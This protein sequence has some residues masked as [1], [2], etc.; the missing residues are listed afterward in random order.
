VGL[1]DEIAWTIFGPEAIRETGDEKSVLARTDS[2]AK[3]LDRIMA[4]SWVI[5]NRAPT[6]LPTSLLAFHPVRIP[7][8]AIRLHPLACYMMN[9]DF[10]GDQAAV[11]LPVTQAG[12]EEAGR[13]LSIA[14]HLRRNP[15]LIRWLA[16]VQDMVWG[17]ASLS[18]TSAGRKDIADLIGMEVAAP[19]GYVTR[20][21]LGDAL[22]AVLKRDGAETALEAAQRL[23]RR[24]FQ[25]A[26][27][28]GASMSP[29]IGTVLNRPTPPANDDPAQ[30]NR[31][32]RQLAER[33]F[34]QCGFDNADMGPQLLALRSR[35]RG[36]TKALMN[37]LGSRGAASVFGE[38]EKVERTQ[39]SDP[40]A[41]ENCIESQF[42][43]SAVPIKRGWA[44]GLTP[45]EMLACVV[46][47]RRGLARTTE[48]CIRAGY[49]VRE[50]GQT[51]GFNVLA[52]A[53]R[54]PQPGF[55]FAQAAATGE[56]DPLT[57]LDSRLF[58]GLPA[59]T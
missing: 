42:F 27:Q 15:A 4:G 54:S 53:M 17:L 50:S 45:P 29:F 18:R 30:W 39:P 46:P 49:A 34:A 41:R 6:M 33:I 40:T 47:A 48:E 26:I 28:S 58:V 51:R 31:Y 25:E 13:L 7:D 3:A 23:M 55:V 14:G 19:D 32:S 57:D 52:R 12:Q 8:K 2:A 37:L 43:Q 1:P 44:Q 21:T 5:L 35:A 16:P 10:D 22:E 59:K 36:A 11:F 56:I 38:L 9:S 24:G 20:D